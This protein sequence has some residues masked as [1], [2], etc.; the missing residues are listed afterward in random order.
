MEE[1]QRE[2]KSRV[3]EVQLIVEFTDICIPGVSEASKANQQLWYS[4]KH[5]CSFSQ[6]LIQSRHGGVHY[7]S[8]GSGDTVLLIHSSPRIEMAER[9]TGNQL[10]S[11]PG[12]HAQLL[13]V[14]FVH[15]LLVCFPDLFLDIFLFVALSTVDSE[16]LPLVVRATM[17]P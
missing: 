15:E 13:H 10:L 8:N 5:V 9:G 3:I 2:G 14:S 16:R 4:G 12:Q 7:K 11:L 6:N 17:L 1:E